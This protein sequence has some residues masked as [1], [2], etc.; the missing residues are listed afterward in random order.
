[1]ITVRDILDRKGSN[2]VSVAPETTALEAA[3]LMNEHRIGALLVL[4]ED[5][6]VGIVTERDI[7]RRVVATAG[8]P[9]KVIVKEILSTP[10]ACCRPDTPLEECRKV[11]TER[12]IR[13]LPVV[14]RGQLRGI[15]TIG[16]LMAYEISEHE[17]T[18]K[19]LNE[20]IFGHPE[21]V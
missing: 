18:I 19:Y 14:D 7:L 12:R 4:E 1:M 3:R 17:T 10:V 9:A 20:Y 11:I 5:K 15:I 8:D 6:L 2:V 13:H 21:G 16:D